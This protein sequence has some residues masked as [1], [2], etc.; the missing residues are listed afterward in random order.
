[1]TQSIV[2][3]LL[4]SLPGRY[5]QALFTLAKKAKNIDKIYEQ[6]LGFQKFL[7][8]NTELNTVLTS[9]LFNRKERIA[10]CGEIVKK[11]K[12][13]TVLN[14]FLMTLV[15]S[16]RLQ[17]LDDMI[18]VYGNLTIDDQKVVPIEIYSAVE[19]TTKQKKKLEGSLKIRFG[20]SLTLRYTIRSGL[21]GGVAIRSRSQVVDATLLMQFQQLATSMKGT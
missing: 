4:T 1:M 19:L 11:L 3:G 16:D 12:I 20:K 7:K 17:Y 9:A 15:K 21:I 18:R 8:E 6:L 13:H 10:T 14:N 5:A 2:T